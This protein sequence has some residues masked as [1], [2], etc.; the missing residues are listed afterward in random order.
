MGAKISGI[1]YYLPDKILDNI[2]LSNEFPEWDANKINEKIGIERRHITGDNETALD[3]A[4]ASASKVLAEF[5]PSSIDFI[6]LCT[7]SPDYFLPTTSCILQDKLKLRT[8]IGAL[9]INQG[10][11]GFIYGL[12]LAKGLINSE[13]CKNI[14][15]VT[16]ETYS[17]HIHPK[18]KSN[19][20][21]FG[22]GSAAT[23][24]SYAGKEHIFGFELGTDGS[25]KDNLIVRRGGLRNRP[26]PEEADRYDSAGNVLNDNYLFM[27]GPGIFNFTLERVP[28]LVD[29]V[30]KKNNLSIDEV[31]YIIFHQANKYMLDYLKRKLKFPDEKF[32]QDMKETGNT[33][34][35]TIPIAL[36]ESISSK[37]I[38]PGDKVLIVGFGVGYSWGA[39]IIEI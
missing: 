7:Q 16:A 28:H 4:Y 15:L 18:D 5:D 35:S 17:K 32:Y 31:D 37:R 8:N 12:A 1:G 34:S 24:I 38:K 14:L 33:V 29:S 3:L 13:I 36:K 22:D 25:G 23:I 21:I 10:C 11:S 26:D 19:R 20:S 9:D 39:T 2:Q 6:I 30:L 27:D